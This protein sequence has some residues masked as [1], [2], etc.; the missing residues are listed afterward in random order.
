MQSQDVPLLVGQGCAG[1]L[2]HAWGLGFRV[3]GLVVSKS[4]IP[5]LVNDG[6]KPDKRRQ[7][8]QEGDLGEDLQHNGVTSF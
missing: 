1:E 6:L 8:T 4:L 5:K 7:S 3:W 2:R